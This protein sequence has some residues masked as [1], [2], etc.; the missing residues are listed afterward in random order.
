MIGYPISEVQEH[1]G[2]VEE[3]AVMSGSGPYS[4]A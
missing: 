4:R 2:R 3:A 1:L